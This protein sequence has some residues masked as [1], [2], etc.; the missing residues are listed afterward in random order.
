MGAKNQYSSINFLGG[1]IEG[2]SIVNFLWAISALLFLVAGKASRVLVDRWV[3]SETLHDVQS[4][5]R[6]C[7][8]H[9][10]MSTERGNY[11][12]IT[13]HAPF[14]AIA[15]NQKSLSNCCMEAL[16]HWP[17]M[18][19]SGRC[20]PWNFTKKYCTYTCH[21]LRVQSPPKVPLR[22]LSQTFLRIPKQ[23]FVFVSSPKNKPTLQSAKIVLTLWISYR[24]EDELQ[25]CILVWRDS[26]KRY[27][28]C[29]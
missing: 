29:I 13:V 23:Y 5:N 7:T 9:A 19:N 24:T 14:L 12:L 2:I 17:E 26:K 11:R 6:R 3:T 8:G 22:P 15:P 21:I 1:F 25:S 18:K 10:T 4:A 20:S 16:S 27:V 28:H